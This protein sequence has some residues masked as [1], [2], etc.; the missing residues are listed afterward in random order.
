M[1]SAPVNEPASILGYPVPEFPLGPPV[2]L[3]KRVDMVE[4]VVVIRKFVHEFPPPQALQ[5][6]VFTQFPSSVC[7]REFDQCHGAK[8]FIAGASQ[9]GGPEVSCPRENVSKKLPVD[10]PKFLEI[11]RSF[12]ID[13][14]SQLDQA[15][16]HEVCFYD[17]QVVAGGGADEVSEN[18][19]FRIDIGIRIRTIE[20]SRVQ[21]VHALF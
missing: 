5:K 2:A 16:C 21:T 20:F 9:I 18:P 7:G 8:R 15:C 17:C 3:A 1:D 12:N 10:G 14:V 19:G 6:A 11:P 13:A 4:S